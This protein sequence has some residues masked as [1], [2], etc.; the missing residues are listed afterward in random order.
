VNQSTSF[1][2][3]SWHSPPRLAHVVAFV[4]PSVAVAFVAAFVVVGVVVFV[5]FGDL[6]RSIALLKLTKRVLSQIL[7]AAGFGLDGFA[8]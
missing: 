8:W 7:W 2:C 5:V 4:A 6:Y 1:S 3:I